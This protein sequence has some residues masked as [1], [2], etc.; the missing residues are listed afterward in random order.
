MSVELLSERMSSAPARLAGLEQKK[1]KL[2]AG[3]DADI[4]IWNPDDT[5]VV[6]AGTL[7]H[8]HPITPYHGRALDGVVRGTYVCG[9]EVFRDGAVVKENTGG[10]LLRSSLSKYE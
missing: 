2:A 9:A 3:Y 4:V 6:D 1:G 7:Y 10:L 5:F 8:R